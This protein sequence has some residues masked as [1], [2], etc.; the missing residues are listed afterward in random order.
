[1]GMNSVRF[2]G[3]GVFLLDGK[4]LW[5]TATSGERSV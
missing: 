2:D 5:E 1:M 4:P 3:G